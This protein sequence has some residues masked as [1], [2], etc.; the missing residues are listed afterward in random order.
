NVFFLADK[1]LPTGTTC[2]VTYTITNVA[3]G[4]FKG[5]L[6]IKN[7]GTTAINGWRLAFELAQ[8]QTLQSPVTGAVFSQTGP[9]SLNKGASNLSSNAVI[10]PG[11]T[12]TGVSFTGTWDNLVNQKPGNISL[13]GKRCTV[14]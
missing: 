9:N 11:A 4:T 7:T 3:N 6:A 12:L 8:G 1:N 14:P 5:N 10:N 13:N 2:Q